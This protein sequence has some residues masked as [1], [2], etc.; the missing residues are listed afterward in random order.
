[1]LAP[2]PSALRIMLHICEDFAKLHGL[3]FNANKT[4]LI[5]FGKGSSNET[6]MFCGTRLVFSQE[7][8]HL[9]HT[10]LENLNDSLD[11]SRIFCVELTIFCVHSHLLTL[12]FSQCCKSHR[13]YK[14][15]HP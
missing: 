8:I 4:Q 1:M 10:L 5:R 9:G 14:E 15:S 12:L 7:V 11:I 2:S 3:R 13:V 6:F